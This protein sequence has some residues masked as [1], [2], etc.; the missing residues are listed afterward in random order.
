MTTSRLRRKRKPQR[1][2]SQVLLEDGVGRDVLDPPAG[3]HDHLDKLVDDLGGTA[4]RAPTYL[5][6]IAG[7]GKS[8]ILVAYHARRDRSILD[9]EVAHR[10][11]AP[12]PQA[13]RQ[14][15]H[16]QTAGGRRLNGVGDHALL[17]GALLAVDYRGRLPLD[18][19]QART[20]VHREVPASRPRGS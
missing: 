15:E 14:T 3:I 20:V 16:R 1:R 6:T 13:L 2:G 11:D 19:A 9:K 8:P 5:A 10:S 18:P 17:L 4:H 12:R 7:Q